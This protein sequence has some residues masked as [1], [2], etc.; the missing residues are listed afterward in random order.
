MRPRH[1]RELSRTLLFVLHEAQA[2][3]IAAIGLRGKGAADAMRRERKRADDE[4]WTWIV[5]AARASET[6]KAN[7]DDYRS[8]LSNDTETESKQEPSGTVEPSQQGKGSTPERETVK[9]PQS[10]TETRD[11][12]AG[13]F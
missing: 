10:A 8:T 12:G 4:R 9:G 11:D 5:K 2:E 13:A 3:A 7:E 6:R 1:E